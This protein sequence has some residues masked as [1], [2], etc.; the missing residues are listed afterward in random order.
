[1]EEV[2]VWIAG[3][4]AAASVLSAA[5]AIWRAVAAH[6]DAESADEARRVAEEHASAAQR[7]ADE[8]SALVEQVKP[9]ALEYEVAPQAMGEQVT[10]TTKRSR[11]VVIR[12]V[13]VRGRVDD[14]M[15]NQPDDV[16]GDLP[17]T[18]R[19]GSQVVLSVIRRQRIS[20]HLAL[21]IDGEEDLFDVY[22]PP[23]RDKR[24]RRSE[25]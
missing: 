11:P 12:E 5:V 7:T 15:V 16:D 19:A 13:D 18:V 22:L 24:L 10:I 25:E 23:R 2:S 4:A 20:A 17:I 1:M 14:Y 8:L 9:A 6:K 21:R 3:F